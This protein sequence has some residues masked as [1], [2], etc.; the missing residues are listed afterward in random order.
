M[1]RVSENAA[2]FI[3]SSLNI[4][5]FP[6]YFADEEYYKHPKD[7]I[8]HKLKSEIYSLESKIG[9]YDILRKQMIELEIQY[10]DLMV[11]KSESEGQVRGRINE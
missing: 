11:S 1:S 4:S 6:Q 8:I 3:K 5:F 2:L 7:A 9:N 10:R